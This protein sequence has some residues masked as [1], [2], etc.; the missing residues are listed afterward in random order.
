MSTLLDSFWRAVM[1]CMHPRV[2][3]LSL[4]PFVVM[5]AVSLALSYFFWEDALGAMRGSLESYEL[6]RDMLPWLEE[7]GLGGLH[8]IMAAV[9]LLFLVIPLIVI[10]TLLLVA[11]FMTP[12]MV[13]LVSAR[14]F[15]RLER[16]KGGS[17]LGSL[18]WA[19]RSTALAAAALL[20]SIPLWLVPPLILILPPLIWGWLT[21]RIMSYDALAAHASSEELAEIFDEHRGSLLAIGLLCGYLGTV[22]SLL[23]A[24]GALF[25]AL[26][27]VLLPLAIWV[28]TLV[29]AFSSL[30]FTHY[31]LAALE[32]LRSKRS[33]AAVPPSSPTAS[34]SPAPAPAPAPELAPAPAPASPPPPRETLPLAQDQPSPPALPPSPPALEAPGA[35]SA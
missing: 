29:F 26:M 34:P 21:Y 30:W 19:L 31:G 27:P 3:F 33:A 22:P 24:S 35:Q 18:L 32:Q 16:K 14:R 6:F 8:R 2:I 11:L 4:L 17:W 15:P 5:G 7:V 20:G 1:Y 12:A 23:W 25:V 9:L 10:A 13:A 28:Y